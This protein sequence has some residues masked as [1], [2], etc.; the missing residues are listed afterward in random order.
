MKRLIL[1]WVF[2]GLA[3]ILIAGLWFPGIFQCERHPSARKI[4][5]NEARS[6][7]RMLAM[8]LGFYQAGFGE[9][10]SGDHVQVV[11][12]LTGKNP[13][14]LVFY[15]PPHGRVNARGELLDPWGATYRFDTSDPKQ[16]RVWSCGPNRRDDGGAEGSDDIISWR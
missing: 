12:S 3:G 6:E 10:P 4:D 14:N 8:T 1:E 15:E 2:P 9:L 16:P 7:T 13:R 11:A 5:V